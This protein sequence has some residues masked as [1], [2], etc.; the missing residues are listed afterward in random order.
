MGHSNSDRPLFSMLRCGAGFLQPIGIFEGAD[1]IGKIN[2]VLA[3]VE[4][5]LGFIPLIINRA[6]TTGYR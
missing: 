1:G 6:Q 2:A 3:A 5:P 4:E